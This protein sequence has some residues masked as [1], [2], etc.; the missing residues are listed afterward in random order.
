MTANGR[1]GAKHSGRATNTALTVNPTK[2]PE[3]HSKT[4]RKTVKKNKK[5]IKR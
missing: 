4:V 5:K 1:L 2:D 3:P